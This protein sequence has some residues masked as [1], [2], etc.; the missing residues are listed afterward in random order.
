MTPGK[1]INRVTSPY[2]WRTLNGKREFH[3]GNDSVITGAVRAIWDCIKTEISYGYNGGRGN[4]VRLYYS[5]TLRV[6]YQ[7]LKS[8]SIVS[9]QKVKQGDA[10][11]VMGNT[12]YSFGAHLHTE[13]QVLIN[14]KWTPVNPAPYTEVPN[15]VGSHAGNDNYD[16]VTAPADPEPAPAAPLYIVAAGPMSAGDRR[17]MESMAGN[18]GLPHTASQATKSNLTTLT[19]GPASTGDMRSLEKMAEVL[20]LPVSYKVA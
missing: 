17:T 18:L 1:G 11:G 16:K 10:V 19:I 3:Y 8:I 5:K 13:V 6:I 14:G 2:G 9:G 7:H 20:N 4:L 15:T 12:G